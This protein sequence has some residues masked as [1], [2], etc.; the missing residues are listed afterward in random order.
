MERRSDWFAM[1]LSADE[2]RL[3]ETLAQREGTS[4][5]EA[6]RAAIQKALRDE[7]PVKAEALSVSRT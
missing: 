1:R 3:I 6:V 5:S 2:R 7:R 4:A